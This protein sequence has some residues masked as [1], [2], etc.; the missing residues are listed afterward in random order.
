MTVTK[1]DEQVIRTGYTV[2]PIPLRLR[3]KTKNEERG[4]AVENG[5]RLMVG[6]DKGQGSVTGTPLSWKP[7]D[8][9]T[10]PR[11]LSMVKQALEDF[12]RCLHRAGYRKEVG[13]RCG[14]SVLYPDKSIPCKGL[15]HEKC[16]SQ[17]QG[18]LVENKL[19]TR[20]DGRKVSLKSS[21]EEAYRGEEVRVCWLSA[22]GLSR[23]EF[24]R[25]V[26]LLTKRRPMAGLLK[27]TAGVY[28]FTESGW[29][30]ALLVHEKEGLR[31]L[32][33]LETTWS[34]LGGP[35]A[36]LEVQP[37]ERSDDV[38]GAFTEL[39]VQAEQAIPLMVNRGV[40]LPT[41][42]L[43]LLEE[44]FGLGRYKVMGGLKH[45]ALRVINRLDLDAANQPIGTIGNGVYR[46]DGRSGDN[47]EPPD[48][49]IIREPSP[50]S[51]CPCGTPG[52]VLEH[53]GEVMCVAIRRQLATGELVELDSGVVATPHLAKMLAWERRNG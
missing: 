13:T 25:A 23:E 45:A 35:D 1:V 18:Y 11:T 12:P 51:V 27:E 32:T 52:C 50:P 42:G 3:G 38:V 39:L 53:V 28:I 16:V 5:L 24:Q 4:A 17:T 34:E 44:E 26:D 30:F 10:T 22:P 33:C 31:G 46:S 8:A 20:V 2:S 49:D 36:R 19:G 6:G 41:E 37:V 40:L 9:V 15:G 47:G 48:P 21:L 29:T 14:G 7:S 43:D